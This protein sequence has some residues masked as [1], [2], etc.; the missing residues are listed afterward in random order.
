MKT[1]KNLFNKIISFENLLLAAQKASQGKKGKFNVMRFNFNLEDNLLKL[2]HELV[3]K[4]YWPGEYHAFQIY[5]PKPRLISAAPF[6]DRV[7]H[8]AL[9]N[10]IEPLFDNTFIYHCYANRKNKG[11]HAGIRRVQKF[12]RANRFVLKC[13]IKKYFPSIDHELLKQEIRWKIADPDTLWLIDTIIDGSNEQE[14]VYDTFP[15][16]DLFGPL[17]RRKGLPLGNLTS[18][19]F[20]NLFLNRFDHFVK[21]ILKANYYA[22]YVDDFL[23]ASNDLRYLKDAKSQIDNYLICL[24][25][26]LHPKKCHILQGEKGV[27]FLGQIIYPDYRLL[28]KDNIRRFCKK[29]KRFE[30]RLNNGEMDQKRVTSSIQGWKGHAC[31]A[32]TFRLR[33]DLEEKFSY[34]DLELTDF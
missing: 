34:L 3:N 2:Q 1:F 24:R 27:A 29:M 28:K 4:T 16:D 20:A 7:V 33:K 9:C 5:D 17:K 11:T 6:Q 23:I 25:L 14:F 31:Q 15:G 13:D 26:K 8:H 30:H 22:R 18:Q 10:I 19:F 12:L 21:E 32:D